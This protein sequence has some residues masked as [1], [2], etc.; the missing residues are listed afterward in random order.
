MRER[1][2]TTARAVPGGPREAEAVPAGYK[3]TEVGVIPEDWQAKRIG[4]IFEVRAGGDLDPTKSGDVQSEKHKYPIYANS[5][6]RQGL[7]GFCAEADCRPGSITVT[8]RGTLGRAFY[9]DT[10]FVAIGR[11]LVLDS[12]V[13]MDAR[14]FCE[15]INHGVRFA[16]ESTGVPQLTAPQVEGYF[17]PVPSFPEQY[18][19]AT[20]LSDMDAEIAVLEQRRDKARAIKQGMMQQLLTGRVRLVKTGAGS[21]LGEPRNPRRKRNLTEKVHPGIAVQ[22][23]GGAAS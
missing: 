13:N 2:A 10:P 7:Y 6:A 1:Q 18:A 8:A 22:R 11:L 21:T 15:F 3:H 9:R 14:Y 19:I 23:P 20:V 17:L 4:E 16:V 12:K 5:L